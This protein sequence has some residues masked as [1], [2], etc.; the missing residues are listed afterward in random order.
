MRLPF[1]ALLI[2]AALAVVLTAAPAR[3]PRT[4]VHSFPGPIQPDAGT[5]IGVDRGG[6]SVAFAASFRESGDRYDPATTPTVF[7]WGRRTGSF[8]GIALLE[9]GV[10]GRVPAAFEAG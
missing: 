2:G 10:V 6:R 8:T 9:G 1:R 5:D 4:T 3:E 7:L